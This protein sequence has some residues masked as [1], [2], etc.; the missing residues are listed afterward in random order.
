MIAAARRNH[1][2]GTIHYTGI[3]LFESH[4]DPRAGI[5]L[6]AAHCRLAKT[7]VRLRLL[8]GDPYSALARAANT[9]TGTDLIV[10]SANVDPDSLARVEMAEEMPRTRKKRERK[11]RPD[12]GEPR[13]VR[14]RRAARPAQGS[15]APEASLDASAQE[16]VE[17]LRVW[18]RAEAQRRRVPA[19]R[20]L[21]DRAVHALAA[22]TNPRAA[23]CASGGS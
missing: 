8:P 6:K 5:S 14:E 17:A 2:P 15:L 3:D 16:V 21:T 1:W 19:F 11:E 23:S 20:I 18:R 9:L 22:A 12:K 10:V 7:G 13:A 4:T